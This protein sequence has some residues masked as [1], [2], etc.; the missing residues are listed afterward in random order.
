LRPILDGFG[1]KGPNGAKGGKR[2]I[3]YSLS[4]AA[5]G[6]LAHII[7][8]QIGTPNKFADFRKR[9][10]PKNLRIYDLRICDLRREKK[11]ACPP[12]VLRNSDV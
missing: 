10:D 5:T 4:Y 7:N 8:L 9:N 6:G 12:L 1:M 2:G 11:F 3:S